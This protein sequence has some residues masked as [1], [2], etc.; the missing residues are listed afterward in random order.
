VLWYLSDDGDR[1]WVLE[2]TDEVRTRQADT[3]DP[4]LALARALVETNQPPED[5]EA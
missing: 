3:D 5:G 2:G 1:V 4:L